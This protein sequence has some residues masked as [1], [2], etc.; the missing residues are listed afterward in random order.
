MGRTLLF[1]KGVQMAREPSFQKG[2]WVGPGMGPAFQRGVW[3]GRGP[4]FLGRESGGVGEYCS[5]MEGQ[6][7]RVPHFKRD[8]SWSGNFRRGH[9]LGRGLTF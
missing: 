8:C 3:K 1:Q 9:L 2:V 7:G 6:W 5:E 4:A